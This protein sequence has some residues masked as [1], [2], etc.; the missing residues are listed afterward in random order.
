MAPP[1]KTRTSGRSS[2]Q[3]SSKASKNTGGK[4]TKANEGKT[5]KATDK[6]NN[7]RG[8]GRPSRAD[9]AAAQAAGQTTPPTVDVAIQAEVPQHFHQPPSPLQQAAAQAL[10]LAFPTVQ[11]LFCPDR[12]C[13]KARKAEKERDRCDRDQQQKESRRKSNKTY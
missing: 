13:W 1:R 2:T 8:R 5:T 4:Q 9:Q 7:N 11:D 6:A 3:A 10:Q 12:E